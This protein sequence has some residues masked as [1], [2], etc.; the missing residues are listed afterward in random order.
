[1]SSIFVAK[2]IFA[3]GKSSTQSNKQLIQESAKCASHFQKFEHKYQIPKD[4]LHSISLQESGRTH[5]ILNKKIPWPWTVNVEGKG[6]YFNSKQEAVKFVKTEK[7][8]GKKSIDVGCMQISLLYHGNEFE[9]I[10]DAF[11][12]K[13]N[14][15]FGAIFLREKFEQYKSWNKA[16]ANYHSANDFKGSKYKESVLKIASNI[17]KH[18]FLT[19]KYYSFVTPQRKLYPNRYNSLISESKFHSLKNRYKSNMVYYQKKE[20]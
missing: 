10:E 1:M 9:S 2:T 11:E 16:V 15:E 17:D 4:L 3:E 6:Y 7:Q 8:K 13:R 14:I 5:K 12:P 19:P 18:K 20:S